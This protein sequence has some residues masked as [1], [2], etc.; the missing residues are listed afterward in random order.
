MGEFDGEVAV[1][2]DVG[3]SMGWDV[4]EQ[5]LALLF[6]L[7][8]VAPASGVLVGAVVPNLAPCRCGA[9]RRPISQGGICV[10][11]MPGRCCC[12]RTAARESALAWSLH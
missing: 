1:F 7:W 3:H 9:S 12:A 4:G 8:L 6:R 11:I 5:E 10:A 2:V